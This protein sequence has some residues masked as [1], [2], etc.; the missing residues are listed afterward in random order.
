M[1][2]HTFKIL[3]CFQVHTGKA[4]GT[5]FLFSLLNLDPGVGGGHSDIWNKI[6][7]LLVS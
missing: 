2:K 5:S 3:P 7:Q 4:K 6:L 1:E